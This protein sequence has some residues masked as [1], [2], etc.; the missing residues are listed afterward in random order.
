MPSLDELDKQADQYGGSK[1]SDKFEFNKKVKTV[2][3]MRL[4]N[5]P[6]ILATHFFGKGN[7]S[8]ICV[9]M[10]NGC[11]YH[12]SED[13]APSLKLVTYIVDR[14]DGNVK[15]AELPLSVRYALRD[16]QDDPEFVFADFP[17][18]YDVKITADPQNEDPKSKY[19]LV[20]GRVNSELTPDEQKAFDEAMKK[21]TPEQYVE[22]RKAKTKEGVQASGVPDASKIDYPTEE[23]NPD[24]IPF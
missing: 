21:I 9:G 1:K 12:K 22:K 13:K 20:G 4:L 7:P 8:V 19:R 3:Q 11:T 2:T 14:T 17:M 16:L 24:D 6:A 5:F 23:I 18:P 10:D 15:L